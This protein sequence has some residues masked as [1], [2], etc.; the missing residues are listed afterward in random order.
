MKGVLCFSLESIR[1]LAYYHCLLADQFCQVG[2]I[3]LKPAFH[4]QRSHVFL[5]AFFVLRVHVIFVFP[6]ASGTLFVETGLLIVLCFF[7]ADVLNHEKP[8]TQRETLCPRPFNFPPLLLGKSGGAAFSPPCPLF[9]PFVRVVVSPPLFFGTPGLCGNTGGALKHACLLPCRILAL[10]GAVPTSRPCT[11]IFFAHAPPQ[12][13]R[14]FL[15]VV[16]T[17]RRD[18][19]TFGCTCFSR[20]PAPLR[21]LRGRIFCSAYRFLRCTAL[22][23][24]FFPSG[25]IPLFL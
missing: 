19:E 14:R 12:T 8:F 15:G 2:K 21:T 17:P 24:V 22:V 6:G 23:S 25:F 13:I 9:A 11:S 16:L 4:C 10:V 5:A 1:E 18:L 3:F 20:S 7:G